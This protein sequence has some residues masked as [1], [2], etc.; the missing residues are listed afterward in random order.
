MR[1]FVQG[2]P[3]SLGRLSKDPSLPTPDRRIIWGAI[4]TSALGNL[5]HCQQA[6]KRVEAIFAEAVRPTPAVNPLVNRGTE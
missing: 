4:R 2:R 6:D 1:C 3:G 5:D